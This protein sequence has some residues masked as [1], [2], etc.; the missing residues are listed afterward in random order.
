M[1]VARSPEVA[2]R[3]RRRQ[4]AV[5]ALSVVFVAITTVALARLKPAAPAVE[6]APLWIDTVRRGTMVRQ[7]H[8]VGVLV[9]DEIRWITALTD[10]S[11]ERVIVRPGALVAAD[12]V[13]LELSNPQTE[14]AALNA[15][16]DLKAAKAQYDVLKADLEKDLLSQ[17]AAA[18]S[19]DADA[20][21]TR[22]DVDVN[23]QLASAGLISKLLVKQAQLKAD[24]SEQRRVMEHARL[25]N[26]E[27]SL[28]ARLS[29][30]RA[31]VERRQTLATLR[32]NEALGLSVRAGVGGVVQEVP[33]DAGQR[34]G[35]GTNLAR[36]ANPSRLRAQLQIAETQ[37]KDVAIMQPAEI[38]T[39]NGIVRGHVAR[40]DPAAKNGTVTVDV[41][42]DEALPQ[43]A[44]PDMSVDGTI[45]L[46][47]LENV[48]YV[49]R[50]SF[51]QEK[52]KVS[53]FKLSADGT[54]AVL[55]P[56]ELGRASVNVTEVVRGLNVGDRVVLS[57]MS[58]WDG[59]DRIRLK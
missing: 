11:V 33:V 43:G 40:I 49:G 50:P 9:P 19:A 28:S 8:G 21:Q 53:L 31:E 35:P 10:G 55:T 14:Q 39:R 41:T 5:A 7:V 2:L 32:R 16:L 20:A 48:L 29:V 56:V 34:I 51:G 57:D 4:I 3:R 23:N 52:S 47:R 30:Q 22:M 25:A 46:E 12:T 26:S 59:N 44:K 36:V 13:L 45:Q 54:A 38:D 18:A 17:R 24:V 37:I 6:A 15:E 42:L 58:Q 27:G 1:D